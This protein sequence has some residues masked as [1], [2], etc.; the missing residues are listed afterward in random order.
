MPKMGMMHYRDELNRLVPTG[1][2]GL[3]ELAKAATEV[4]FMLDRVLAEAER[5]RPSVFA[6]QVVSVALIDAAFAIKEALDNLRIRPQ[7]QPPAPGN[8][9]KRAGSQ[10]IQQGG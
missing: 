7:Q 10:T 1:R 8:D 3:I 2:L 4:A 9:G 5:I 6:A